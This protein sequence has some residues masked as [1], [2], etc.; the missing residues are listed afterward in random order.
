MFPRSF[1]LFIRFF[2]LHLD[3]LG[4]LHASAFFYIY[5]G[6]WTLWTLKCKSLILL[7]RQIAKVIGVYEGVALESTQMR[8]IASAKAMAV[9]T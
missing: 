8:Q 2:R 3:G 7:T 6:A 1:A 5:K 9:W 4:L